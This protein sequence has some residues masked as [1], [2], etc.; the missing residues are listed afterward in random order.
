MLVCKLLHYKDRIFYFFLICALKIFSD[1]LIVKPKER[2][3]ETLSS[4]TFLFFLYVVIDRVLNKLKILLQLT[5]V[6]I[7]DLGKQL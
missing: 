1:F 3:K 4:L 6:E 7:S 5:S 2:E